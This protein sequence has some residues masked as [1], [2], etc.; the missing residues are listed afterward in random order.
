MPLLRFKEK[1]GYE[2]TLIVGHSRP[3]TH[4]V[5]GLNAKKLYLPLLSPTFILILKGICLL[6]TESAFTE[7]KYR[8]LLEKVD[9]AVVTCIK[10]S[11]LCCPKQSIKY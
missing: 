3:K 9:I 7:G 1:V 11:F 4:P 5:R 2:L 6:Q 10:T 8:V